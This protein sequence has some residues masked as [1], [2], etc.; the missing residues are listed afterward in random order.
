M[1]VNGKHNCQEMKLTTG[2]IETDRPHVEGI[3]E[4]LEKAGGTQVDE[5][6]AKKLCSIA[7]YCGWYKEPDSHT[8]YAQGE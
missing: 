1:P 8:F 7:G 5:H 6:T 3:K 2:K 4:A